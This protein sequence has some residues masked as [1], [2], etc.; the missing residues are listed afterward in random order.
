MQTLLNLLA[1]IAPVPALP[2]DSEFSA[3]DAR[4]EDSIRR[5]VDDEPHEPA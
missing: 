3:V 4:K 2:G 5:P 1:R